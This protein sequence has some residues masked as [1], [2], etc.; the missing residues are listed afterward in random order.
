MSA[1]PICEPELDQPDE[2][3]LSEHA[4]QHE[5]SGS[6]TQS[7]Q[8]QQNSEHTRNQCTQ[9]EPV[10]IRAL[11]PALEAAVFDLDAF[12][13]ELNIGSMHHKQT[14]HAGS[15]RPCDPRGKYTAP[16]LRMMPENSELRPQPPADS[17]SLVN[18]DHQGRKPP[19]GFPANAGY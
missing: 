16:H 10:E 13:L 15:S 12:L 2:H 17:N 3:V 7:L 9:T 14:A 5:Q 6:H 1:L 11:T 8:S 4:A 18:A 19:P